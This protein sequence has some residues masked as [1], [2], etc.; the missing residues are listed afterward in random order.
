MKH[1]AA[2]GLV[3]SFVTCTANAD[4]ITDWNQTAIGVFKA[5]NITGNPW[6]RGMA[7]VHVAMSDAVN[8]VLDMP[9]M[10]PQ[11]ICPAMHRPKPQPRRRPDKSCS[12]SIPVRKP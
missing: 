9:A 6:T 10:L 4:T 1:I 8:S 7:M 5:E 12:N 11:G 3:M 2:I